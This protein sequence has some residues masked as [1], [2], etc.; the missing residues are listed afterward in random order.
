MNIIKPNETP[1]KYKRLGYS[2]G[3]RFLTS[4]LKTIENHDLILITQNSGGKTW[5]PNFFKS[6]KHCL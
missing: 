2:L 5:R 6:T 4:S 3:L 1:E